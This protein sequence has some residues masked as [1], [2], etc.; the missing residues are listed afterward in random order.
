MGETD[1]DLQ[2]PT[3]IQQLPEDANFIKV[4]RIA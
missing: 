3:T 4:S 1:G 2:D